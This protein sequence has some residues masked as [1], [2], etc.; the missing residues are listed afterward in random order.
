MEEQRLRNAGGASVRFPVF[1][2]FV[3]ELLLE[4][5]AKRPSTL[6]CPRDSKL[7][8]TFPCKHR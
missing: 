2:W 8:D 3:L 5:H 7:G 4:P 1:T 6:F